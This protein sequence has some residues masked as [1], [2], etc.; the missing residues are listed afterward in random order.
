MEAS[1]AFYN[2]LW[3]RC[4]Y[5]IKIV[6]NILILFS[7]TTNYNFYGGVYHDKE[8]TPACYSDYFFL[9]PTYSFISSLFIQA[10]SHKLLLII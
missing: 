1:E 2:F 4:T 6:I 3:R 9:S 5:V 10:K 8:V 7:V